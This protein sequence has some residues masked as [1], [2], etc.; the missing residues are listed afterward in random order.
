M[1]VKMKKKYILC[2]IT[3]VAMCLLSFGI[4]ILTRSEDR[5]LKVGFIFVGDEITPYTE[6]FI[7]AQN[8]VVSVFG[9]KIECVTKYNVTED[10]IELPLEELVNEKCDYIIA[11]SYGYGPVVKDMASLH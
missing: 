10:Q 3:S 5:N 6:N 1:N 4:H 9:D 2:A 11:A 8:H 7:K